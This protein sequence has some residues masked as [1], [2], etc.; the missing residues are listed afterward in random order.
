VS[1]RQEL[2]KFIDYRKSY[3][4]TNAKHRWRALRCRYPTEV[5][6]WL[7]RHKEFR[8]PGAKNAKKIA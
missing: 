8:E 4:E 7:A 5:K 3:G 2:A 6:Q 1:F